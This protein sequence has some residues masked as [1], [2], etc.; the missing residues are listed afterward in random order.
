VDDRYSQSIAVPE[1]VER[2]RK[3]YS[4]AIYDVLD[5][6]G[7]PH[8][9][10]APDIKPVRADMVLAGPAFTIKGIPDPVGDEDLR[11]RRI[12]LFNDMKALGCPVIDTRDCSF[13][14]QVAHYGEMNAVLGQA[15]GAAGALVDGGC[16][17]TGFLLRAD[18]PT[19]C[20][21]QT[22][23]EAFRR[24]SY[25]TWQ[26]PVGLRGALSS[27]VIVH[28]GDFVFGDLD[29]VV[30]VPRDAVVDVLRKT[31]ELVETENRARADFLMP[32][33]DPVEVYKKYGK[34]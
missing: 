19:F 15:C 22:P 13:D 9:A 12:H 3:L 20:R 10:L 21:F 33:A 23:V 18:F 31:E 4:G 27:V 7:L 25:Y 24:W 32:G 26:V 1:L 11:N 34:L 2:Y 17:D 28:P 30:V 16:R 5:H 6:M 14:M 8:Q 29:G